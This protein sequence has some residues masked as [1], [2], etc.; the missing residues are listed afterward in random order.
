MMGKSN[1]Y[2][3]DKTE[4]EAIFQAIASEKGMTPFAA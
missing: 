2:K 1:F 4:K 3:V